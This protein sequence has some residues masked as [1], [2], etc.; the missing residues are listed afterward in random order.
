MTS[1][2]QGWGRFTKLCVQTPLVTPLTR[3]MKVTL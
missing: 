1:D 3:K 2:A